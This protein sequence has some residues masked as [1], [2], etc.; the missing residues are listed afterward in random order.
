MVMIHKDFHQA[1]TEL[2][3]WG[4]HLYDRGLLA[5]R[6]GNLSV[7][8]GPDRFAITPAG[9]CKGRLS[10]RMILLVD[11]QARV[12]AGPG[13]AS[14]E[15]P[16]HLGIY[17]SRSDIRAVVHAHPWAAT[18]FAAAGRSLMD[19]LL[20]ELLQELGGVPLAPFAA[21]GSPALFDSVRPLIA[22]HE[23][24]LL[25]NHG[26]LACSTLNMEDAALRL[27]QL[28]QAARIL[29]G[30]HLLGGARPFDAALL[31]PRGRA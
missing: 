17:R 16:L 12:L 22:R 26:A 6:E 14:S 7:R 20:P 28:E 4:R 10:S 11:G 18:A 27:E 3:E 2:V 31:F 23:V 8:L 9:S 30:A 15:S 29:L 21:P 5:A 25:A 19:P 13:K 1:A 24:L